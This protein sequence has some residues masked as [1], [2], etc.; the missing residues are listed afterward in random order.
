[1]PFDGIFMHAALNEIRE[2]LLGGKVEKIYQPQKEEIILLIRRERLLVNVSGV[3]ARICLSNAK[4]E[5]PPEAPMFCML[6]RKTLTGA[7]LIDIVQPENDRLCRLVF[8]AYNEMGDTV[9][10]ELKVE[11]M[12]RS[13]NIILTE[14]DK[15][16]DAAKRVDFAQSEKRQIL[17]GLKY[18]APPTQDKKAITDIDT[19]ALC[20]EIALS[21]LSAEK[22]LMNKISGLSP[23]W[24]REI[25]FLSGLA[26]DTVGNTIKGTDGLKRTLSDFKNKIAALSFQPTLIS[27]Q[28]GKS[29]YSFLPVHQYGGDIKLYDNIGDLTDDYYLSLNAEEYVKQRGTD[30]MKLIR[31]NIDR[32]SRKLNMLKGEREENEKREVCRVYGELITANIYRIKKGDSLLH[33]VNYYDDNAPETDIP[34]DTRLTP[35]ENA[36][37]YFKTYRKSRTALSFIETESEKARMELSYMRT[38]EDALTRAQTTGELNEIREELERGGYVKKRTVKQ[39]APKRRPRRFVC[40]GFEILAGCN[41]LQ[42]DELTFKTASRHD[43]WFHIK[44]APGAHVIL[45]T[46]GQPPTDAAIEA[47]A[48]VAATLSSGAQGAKIAIDYTKACFV[49]KIH[50]AP[51]GL[52]TYTNQTTLLIAP[53]NEKCKSIEQK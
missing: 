32:L 7:R 6:L 10:R 44:D 47:A 25:C 13:S 31:L 11:I 9:I 36:Q 48:T 52:V 38:V 4:K 17:P 23:L 51:P 2:K 42:N 37:K 8:E 26:P 46:E 1:M 50:G 45:K 43:L 22:T 30:I 18:E 53:D 40:D 19:D 34:L 20:D 35:S 24:A 5:N 27:M 16:I 3:S 21:E 39:R 41:N 12:G 28:N 33:A 49:K 15:I 29:D 14:G